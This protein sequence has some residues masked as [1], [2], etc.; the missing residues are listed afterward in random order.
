MDAED[1]EGDF[2]DN[3]LVVDDDTMEEI[4]ELEGD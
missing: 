1:D 2:M 4:G 3:A